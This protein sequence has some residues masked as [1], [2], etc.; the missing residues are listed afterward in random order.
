LGFQ[1][2]YQGNTQPSFISIV[3][4]DGI[5]VTDVC[6]SS[7]V[8]SGPTNAPTQAPTAAPTTEE[9]KNKEFIVKLFATK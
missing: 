5:Q 9:Q 6:S 7:G 3:F 2:A 8:T 1:V 4:N